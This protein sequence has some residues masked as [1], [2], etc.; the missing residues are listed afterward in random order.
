MAMRRTGLCLRNPRLAI[1]HKG[2]LQE[3]NVTNVTLGG[4]SWVKMLHFIKFGLKSISSLFSHFGTK[5]GGKDR[6]SDSLS[7]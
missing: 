4:V 6:Q 5:N 7:S 1:Q 2:G 3:K